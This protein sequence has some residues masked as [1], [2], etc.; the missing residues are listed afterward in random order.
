MLTI[1]LT[2]SI[3]TGKST[4]AT[5]LAECGLPVFSADETVHEL[6]QGEA[7][8]LVAA[9]F[10]EVVAEGRIDRAA[11]SKRLMQT[12]DD[13]PKLEA[14]V[15]PL[16]RA[17]RQAFLQTHREEGTPMVVLDIPLL[18]ETQMQDDVDV[19]LLVSVDAQ[20]Q[21]RRALKRPGMTEEKLALILAHQIP[22]AQKREKSDFII[23]TGGPFEETHRQ[24]DRFLESVQD[25]PQRAGGPL[26]PNSG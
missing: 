18:F 2:G 1:G 8:P 14:I 22:D 10:P 26:S 24:L 16:V 6:Y 23:D 19:I 3:A 21:R 20:E 17:K 11:L 13:L 15:H 4:A 25:W 9:A 7:V 12:P 5:Y